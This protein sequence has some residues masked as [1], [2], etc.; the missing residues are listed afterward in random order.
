MPDTPGM[1]ST[2]SPTSDR[3]SVTCSGE[4]PMRSFTSADPERR[5][6]ARS[7]RSTRSETS[8]VRSLSREMIETSAPSAVS[9]RTSV[10]ITS[11]ASKLSSP[12]RGIPSAAVNSAQSSNCGSRSSGASVRPSL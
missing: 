8:A 9:V 4:T 6:V 2:A 5:S 10:A 7:K 12:K 3:K 11:S 1:L